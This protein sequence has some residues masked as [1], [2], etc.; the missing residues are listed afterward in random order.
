MTQTTR[1]AGTRTRI[2]QIALDLFIENGYEATSLREIAERLGV[3]KAALYYHF[4]TK[5]DIV[6]S[7]FDDAGARV[8]ELIDWAKQQPHTPET[9]REFLR[10]YSDLLSEQG[11]HRIVRFFDRNQTALHKMKS[12]APMR[13][14]M[15][16]MLDVISEPDM[17]LEDRLRAGLAIFALHSALFVLR[18]PD[19][20]DDERRSA[21]LN[22]ALSLI[23]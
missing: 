19:V 5:D 9:R 12:A 16:E 2:Q 3:T 17:S 22:V 10:R 21:A 15:I 14:W 7:L 18:D 1:E 4:R 6:Q 11:H 20:T 13:E 8:A 23:D